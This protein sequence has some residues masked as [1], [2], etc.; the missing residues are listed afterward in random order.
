MSFSI[1]TK[2]LLLL[3]SKCFGK[4]IRHVFVI[5]HLEITKLFFKKNHLSSISL[6][7]SGK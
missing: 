2:F 5:L 4:F 6:V 1:R 7:I 3:F